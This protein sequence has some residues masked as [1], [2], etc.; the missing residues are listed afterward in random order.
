M[1]ICIGNIAVESDDI[2][3]QI[4]KHETMKIIYDSTHEE[5]SMV[6]AFLF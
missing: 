1:L 2:K 5:R 3:D 4:L 6:K